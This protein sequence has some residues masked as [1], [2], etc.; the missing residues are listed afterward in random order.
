M[1][2]ISRGLPVLV[3]EG[4]VELEEEVKGAG[5][6]RDEVKPLPMGGRLPIRLNQW[7]KILIAMNSHMPAG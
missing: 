1:L 7:L 4:L 5:N 3:E 2:K 6:D